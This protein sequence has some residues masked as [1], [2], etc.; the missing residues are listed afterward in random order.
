MGKTVL[1]DCE[2]P[3]ARVAVGLGEIAEV[4][5][6]SPTEIMVEGKALGETSLIIWDTHG[7]RQFFN[8]T[9][10]ASVS[11]LN[12]NLDAVRRELKKELP[13]QSLKVSSENG[14]IFLR[15]TVD[16]LNSSA[17][18]VK[19]AATGG[20]VVNLLD[21]KVPASEPQILLKVR[22][23][24][25]DRSKE[26]QLGINLFNLGAGNF[27]GGVSTGQFTPPGITLPYAGSPATVVNG[28]GLQLSGFYTALGLGTTIQALETK[29]VVAGSGRAQSSGGERQRGQL[30]GRRRIS[31]SYGSGRHSRVGSGRYHHVQGIWSSPELLFPPLLPA[32]QSVF[33]WPRK[34]ALWIS[35]MP[36]KSQ[37]LRYPPLPQGK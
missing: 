7:G 3:I 6:T 19:I 25:V 2:W 24:S 30:S 22:F 31:L 35:P 15:G 27:V 8:V 14:S 20:K 9:V 11:A 29:G 17:R 32:E 16:N 1:V 36:W 33:R 28:S 34:S 23:I 26:T 21:V 10:R 4:H 5:A 18:A 13:G 12:D 37:D